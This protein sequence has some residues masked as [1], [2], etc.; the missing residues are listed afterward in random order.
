MPRNAGQAAAPVAAAPAKSVAPAAKPAT[1]AVAPAPVVAKVPKPPPPPVDPFEAIVAGGDRAP[2]LFRPVETPG[3]VGNYV[4][5]VNSPWELKLFVGMLKKA[6]IMPTRPKKFIWKT[7]QFA[8]TPEVVNAFV[9]T[10]QKKVTAISIQVDTIV[11][12]SI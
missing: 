8:G 4:I 5:S 12:S 11:K 9:E 6:G 1:P 7:V 2:Q 10:F 3:K